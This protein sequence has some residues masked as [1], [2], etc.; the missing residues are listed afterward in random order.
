MSLQLI[1]ATI[2]NTCWSGYTKQSAKNVENNEQKTENVEKN[3]ENCL[4][5]ISI[6]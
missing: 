2:N 3:V 4:L 5:K 6:D 1:I